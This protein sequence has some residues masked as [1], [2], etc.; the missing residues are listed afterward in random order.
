MRKTILIVDDT[1]ISR[2]FLKKILAVNYDVLEADD[3]DTC[4]QLLETQ[5]DKISLIILD[6]WMPPHGWL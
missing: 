5:R 4:L 1:L 6:A 3:G 2:V